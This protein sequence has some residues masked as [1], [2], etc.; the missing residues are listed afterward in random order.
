MNQ[1]ILDI[2][3]S[4]TVPICNHELGLIKSVGKRDGFRLVRGGKS[5]LGSGTFL[6]AL[7]DYWSQ[8]NAATSA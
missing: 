1:K 7:L 4:Q 5:S 3:I 6:Y 8:Q 2:Y